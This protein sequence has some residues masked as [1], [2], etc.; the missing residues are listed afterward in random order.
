MCFRLK[1]LLLILTILLAVDFAYASDF[2]ICSDE[3]QIIGECFEVHGRISFYNGNPSVRIWPIGTKR[4][5]GVRESEIKSEVLK[6]YLNWGTQIYGDFIVCPLTKSKEG[7]MQIVCLKSGKNLV[8]EQYE[9]GKIINVYK[10]QE[11]WQYN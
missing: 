10:V 9:E 4:I 3:N 2:W 7:H 6:K 8:V 11:T 1:S 5:L